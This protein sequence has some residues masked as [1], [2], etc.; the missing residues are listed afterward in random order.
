MREIKFRAWDLVGEKMLNDIDTIDW[1]LGRKRCSIKIVIDEIHSEI[2]RNHKSKKPQ[3]TLMQY[4]GEKDKNGV[5]IYEGDILKA[6]G[7]VVW[8]QDEFRWSCVDLTWNDKREWHDLDYLT[9][10]FEV[11]GNIYEDNS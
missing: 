11:I 10:A 7:E 1:S 4:T 2:L 5:E 8:N 9:S 6:H 3:F